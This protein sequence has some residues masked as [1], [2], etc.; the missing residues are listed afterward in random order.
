M[1]H[2]GNNTETPAYYMYHLQSATDRWAIA[3]EQVRIDRFSVSVLYKE[4]NWPDFGVI[5]YWTVDDRTMAEAR[6]LELQRIFAGIDEGVGYKELA[7]A[8]PPEER[9]AR[10]DE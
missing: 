1:A 9:H 3:V 7:R 5:R 8:I 6:Y 10:T 2:D 4:A